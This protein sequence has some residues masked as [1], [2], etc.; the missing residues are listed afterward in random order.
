MKR[1][2]QLAVAIAIAAI[3]VGG[4]QAVLATHQPANKVVAAGDKL[5]PIGPGAN[6]TILTAT[7]KT[8][9]PE[10]LILHV[11]LE[12]SITTALVTSNSDPSS[13]SEGDIRVWVEIDGVTVPINSISNPPQPPPAA[14]DPASDGVTF[15]NRTYSRTV[16]DQESPPDG[17]DREQDMI[18]TK[19]SNAFNWLRLNMQSGSHTIKVKA[20]LTT[21]VTGD[22]SAE[23]LIGNR[24]LIATPE[25]LANDATF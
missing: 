18:E 13:S 1:V 12:C 2:M 7:L 22:A 4:T 11:A 6:Q 14:G 25:K 20:T 17:Q 21:T 15:C 23:A 10:D 9:K 3:A 24:S 8:S 5:I 19:T 16:M